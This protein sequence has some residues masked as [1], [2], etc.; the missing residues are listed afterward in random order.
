MIMET[1]LFQ[2]LYYLFTPLSRAFNQDNNVDFLLP[3][4][5][6]A[7]QHCGGSQISFPRV[8]FIICIEQTHNTHVIGL[9]SET[10]AEGTIALAPFSVLGAPWPFDRTQLRRKLCF[11]N[12][13]KF[14][15]FAPGGVERGFSS[16]WLFQ[17]LPVGQGRVCPV[18][19]R[20]E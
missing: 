13:L 10:Q 8:S 19:K 2:G 14:S 6:L 3:V 7:S 16:R 9:L 15:S 18:S 17:R 4:A 1:L 20:S 5:L 11:L 12:K